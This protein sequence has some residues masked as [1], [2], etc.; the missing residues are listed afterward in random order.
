MQNPLMV[1]IGRPNVGKSTL[2]NKLTR[3]RNALVA[4]FAGLTRD[5]QYG[6]GRLGDY[7]FRLID[8]GGLS[9]TGLAAYSSRVS[10]LKLQTEASTDSLMR[11]LVDHQVYSALEEADIVLFVLD[12]KSGVT[13]DD[14]EI[15]ACIRQINKPF[16]GVI[17]KA[18]GIVEAYVYSEFARLG[19]KQMVLVS[20]SHSRGLLRMM[21]QVQALFVQSLKPLASNAIDEPLQ[22][23]GIQFAVVG[24][25]NVGKS[26]LVNRL[27]KEE[28]VVVFDEPGTTRDSIFIPYEHH[29]QRYTLVDTAGIRRRARV[30]NTVEKFSVLKTFNAIE[31]SD[32]VLLLIDAREPFVDQDLHLI[33]SVLEANKP[34]ILVVNK[35]DGLSK[36]ERTQVKRKIERKLNFLDTVPIQF[37][38]A[39]YGTGVGLLYKWINRCYA[40]YTAKPSTTVLNKILEQALAY[41][42]PPMVKGRRIKLRYVHLGGTEPP[43]LVLHGTQTQH[44]PETYQKYLQRTF[45]QKLDLA[46]S[47]IHLEFCNTQNPYVHKKNTLTPRQV[48]KKKRLMRYVKQKRS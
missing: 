29:K 15:L 44:V 36:E 3:S 8:T 34:L 26:T 2:F 4:D 48:K 46:G 35:W 10:K 13:A 33:A 20:A 37:V 6:E 5:R 43:R 38:S 31:V 28:R 9:G 21:E 27:L 40:A 12:A 30:D 11:H 39:L 47:P 18:E 1:L 14:L 16:L 17:N 23:G 41:H 45:K 7:A 32:V 19:L 24:R 25:P 22:Q 42:Q